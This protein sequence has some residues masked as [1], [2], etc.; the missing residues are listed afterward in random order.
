MA[1]TSVEGESPDSVRLDHARRSQLFVEKN[2]KELGLNRHEATIVGEICGAHGVASLDYLLAGDFSVYPFGQVRVP[3]L[4]AL[5]RLA[6]LLDLTYGRAPE[7]IAKNRALPHLSRRH[8]DLH[9][10]I[11]DVHIE[12]LPSWDIIIVAMPKK[13]LG[14]LP[15]LNL[16]EVAQRELDACSPFLRAT[17]IFF[18]KIELRINR[19]GRDRQKG[20]RPN[21]FLSL[22]SYSSR[23]ALLFA[24]RSHETKELVERVVGQR[25]VMVIGESGVGKT[26]L[27]D[28]GLCPQLRQYHFGITRFSLQGD[29]SANLISSLGG[30]SD[31]STVQPSLLATATN[32]MRGLKERSL[33]II[34]DHLEQLFTLG[35]SRPRQVAFAHDL[36]RILGSELPITMLFCIREDYLP[37][38]YNLSTELPELYRRDNTFRLHRLSKE[39]AIQVLHHASD[40]ARRRLEEN[41]IWEVA[42]DLIAEGGGL[43]YPPFLQIVGYRLYSSLKHSVGFKAEISLSHYNHLGRAEH[44]VNQYLE[45]IL[46]RFSIDEKTAVAR[47]LSMM[48]TE[49]YTKK[50]VR[51]EDIRVCVPDFT[52]LD[53]LLA[54]LVQSR[55]IKRSLGEYELI[56]DFLAKKVLDYVNDKR[57]VSLPVRTALQFIEAHCHN[58][59][60]SVPEIAASAQV[61]PNHLTALFRR[62]LGTTVVRE[63][64][65]IRVVHAKRDIAER[66]DPLSEVAIRCGF[67]TANTFSRKFREVEGVSPLQY[68]RIMIENRQQ[69]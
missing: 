68:K 35:T 50:R 43:V 64:G 52:N 37:D 4:A 16:R 29:P 19:S 42:N 61:T 51:V 27:V 63:L 38:L 15:F 67:G 39:N 18:K 6:D 65:R 46:D 58:A 31:G 12:A 3:L 7:L 21:P 9:K 41:L 53:S 17:G 1:T 40:H 56:H 55:I 54:R 20:W 22:K 32:F 30:V 5:L 33:V 47:I 11:S 14:D 2:R 13:G 57:Y 23:D 8:W 62:E 49:Y 25:L 69:Q 48:V 66:N 60:L 24:G 44:I 26:S 10:W 45:T 36:S 28:A 59:T 34:G